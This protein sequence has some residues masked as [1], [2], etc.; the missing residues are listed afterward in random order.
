M[1]DVES[2]DHSCQ[3]LRAKLGSADGDT[4]WMLDGYALIAST[5]AMASQ[6][7]IMSQKW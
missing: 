3:M 4:Q 1:V 6:L 2:S 7:A 5:V